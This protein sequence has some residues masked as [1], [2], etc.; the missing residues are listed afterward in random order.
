MFDEEED[1]D[2]MM[3]MIQDDDDDGK[4][5]R[6]RRSEAK[7]GG[8]ATGLWPQVVTTTRVAVHDV[9][10]QVLSSFRLYMGLN[11]YQNYSLGFL[12][13]TIL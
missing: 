6:K 11:N 7:W 12:S 4:E 1:D 5:R 2:V 3:M 10:T 8:G 9:S 13:L